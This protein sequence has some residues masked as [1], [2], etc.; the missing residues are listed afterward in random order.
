MDPGRDLYLTISNPEN[1]ST[2]HVVFE[3]DDAG[4]VPLPLNFAFR[5]QRQTGLCEF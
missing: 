5:E 3:I 1:V 4:M 2:G